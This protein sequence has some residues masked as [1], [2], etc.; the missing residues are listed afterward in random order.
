MTYSKRS[1]RYEA[2]FFDIA[3][4]IQS[5]VGKPLVLNFETEA[6]AHIMRRKLY[7]YRGVLEREAEVTGHQAFP[8]FIALEA[9]VKGTQLTV[10]AKDDTDLSK[11]LRKALAE[12]K[13]KT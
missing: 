5:N 11:F 12:A 4:Y 1:T 10:M 6:E 13:E 8:R 3:D 2:E 9:R 7:A